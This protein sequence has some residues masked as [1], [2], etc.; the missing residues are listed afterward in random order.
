VHQPEKKRLHLC[1]PQLIELREHEVLT[2]NVGD[3]TSDP[4]APK[5]THRNKLI[6]Q[7]IPIQESLGTDYQFDL[8]NFE[9]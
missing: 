3:E 7:K 1:K 8:I 6:R 9:A 2:L 4:W 5:S